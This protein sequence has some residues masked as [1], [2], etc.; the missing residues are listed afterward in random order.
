MAARDFFL[1][2][3]QCCDRLTTTLGMAKV[4]K[5]DALLFRQM[6]KLFFLL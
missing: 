6:P 5:G 4:E 1:G 2:G 3:G